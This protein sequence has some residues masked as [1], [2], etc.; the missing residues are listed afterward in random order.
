[1]KQMF[2]FADYLYQHPQ[3]HNNSVVTKTVNSFIKE[4]IKLQNTPQITLSQLS[5]IH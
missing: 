5:P 2:F 1:M 3:S 4:M